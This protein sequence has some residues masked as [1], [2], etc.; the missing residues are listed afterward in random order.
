MITVVDQ[1]Q[2]RSGASA[3]GRDGFQFLM[4]EVGLGHAGAVLS[5]EASRLA[6]SSSDWHRLIEICG[7]ADTLVI[8]EDGI[9]DPSHYNDRLLLGFKGTMSEAELHWLRQR[10]LGGMLEKAHKGELR[11]RLPTGLVHDTANQVILDPDEQVQQAVRLVFDLFDQLGTARAV[12]KHFATHKLAFPTRFWGGKRDGDLV[13]SPLPLARVLSILHNPAYA[14]AYVYGRTQTRRQLPPGSAASASRRIRH[15]PRDAWPIV[16]QDAHPPYISWAQFLHNQQRLDD[17]RTFR[18][19]ARRGAAREGAALLQGIGLCGRCGR[20]LSVRYPNAGTIPHYECN[21]LHAQFTGQP[22]QSIRGDAVDA[23]VAQLFLEAVQPAQLEVSLA[24]LEELDTRARQIDQLWQLR[25][26]RAQYQADLARRRFLAVE[27]EN[28]LVARN[29]ERDW[30]AKLTEIESLQR[31][32]ASRPQ[33]APQLATPKERQRILAL[34]KDVP[35][36]WQAASTTHAQRKQLLRCLVK[37]V[38]LTK[39]DTTIHVSIR[40]QTEALSELSVPRP[41]RA[42]DLTRT[43]PAVVER[44]RTLALSHTDHQIAELLNR[45][46]LTSGAGLPF[47]RA[48]VNWIRR[49]YDISAACPNNPAACPT[50][51]RADGRYSARAA[52]NSLQVHMSTI[53]AWCRAGRLDGLQDVPLGPWWIKLTPEIIAE[54]R[55]EQKR[56][57][58]DPLAQ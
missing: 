50:G 23:A 34:A 20:G 49:A 26:E 36:L 8:D 18:A 13:W 43:D 7:L 24:T 47:D 21:Q 11:V 27:P 29:L 40:W 1:D 52:A 44:V 30:N 16:L 32:W 10:L 39:Q 54:L 51:Q 41:P 46:Q 53:A 9:Y 22:C 35:A 33:A 45:E 2:G 58:S 6:R 42:C 31:E 28:R 37:E 25:I 38:T 55:Q 19:E 14:G 3:E 56:P 15:I 12:V 48:K 17:N 5:L 57:A 4:A